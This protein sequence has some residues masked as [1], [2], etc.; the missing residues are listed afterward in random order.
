MS[1]N[2]GWGGQTFIPQ[3]IDRIAR[4]RAII[5]DAPVLEVDGGVDAG[6]AGPCAAAGATRLVAGTAVFGAPDP[7][8]AFAEIA[9]AASGAVQ[10]GRG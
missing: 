3:S 4:L 6:N 7:A 8:A 2:P 5:G 10:S 1:V 9:A